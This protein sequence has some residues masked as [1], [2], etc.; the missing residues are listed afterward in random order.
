MVDR[1]ERRHLQDGK[2]KNRESE[3]HIHHQRRGLGR[4]VQRETQ[5]HMGL[6]DWQAESPRQSGGGEKARRNISLEFRRDLKLDER[7]R[8]CLGACF[9]P[10]EIKVAPD[11]DA[12]AKR[13]LKRL[14]ARVARLYPSLILAVLNDCVMH[15]QLSLGGY[16]IIG[17]VT[18]VKQISEDTKFPI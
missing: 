6:Y 7:G 9:S 2:G 15:L 17:A 18:L 3:R 14:E 13:D 12:A 8:V 1:R 16:D 10:E 11:R 4:H 5:R